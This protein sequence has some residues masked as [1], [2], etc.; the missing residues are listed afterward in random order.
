MAS[1]SLTVKGEGTRI[2]RGLL[3]PYA[4]KLH[5]SWVSA[6]G[7]WRHRRGWLVGIEAENG[8]VGFGDCAPLPSWGEDLTDIERQL[9]DGLE[10]CT[11][12]DMQQALN[13]LS[14][15][16]NAPA[17]RCGLETA[18]LDFSA[19]TD[20]APLSHWLSGDPAVSVKVNA[21][22]GALDAQTATRAHD[23]IAQGYRV[24]KIKI[25]VSA[26]VQE[27]SALRA[28]V[29]T[30]PPGIALRLDANGRWSIEQAQQFLAELRELPVES[31][32]EP[33]DAPQSDAL[34]ALQAETPFPLA[35]DESLR[36]WKTDVLLRDPPVSR[37]VL[38]PMMLGGPLSAL[39]LAREAESAGL[40]CVVTSTVDSAA[41]IWMALHLAAA[42]NNDLVHG[43]A[44][45]PWLAQDVG[46][47]PLI[48]QGSMAVP[49]IPG[50]GFVP[51]QAVQFG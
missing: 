12:V 4:L 37:I 38:K 29:E 41:G 9:H 45:G 46:D 30:L 17:V 47:G 18:L 10:A 35:L 26:S 31:L 25:G 40:Q 16:H 27:L 36:S 15:L 20:G 14:T 39:K 42:L 24:L 44:T 7:A 22:L 8:L 2:V 23:A 49:E 50:L 13:N 32:E 21:A 34:K 33:L 28:L 19:R 48:E 51:D 3:A 43:L 6:R 5:R 1:E 11:G